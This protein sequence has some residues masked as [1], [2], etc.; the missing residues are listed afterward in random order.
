MRIGGAQ[1]AR[2]SCATEIAK[3]EPQKSGIIVPKEG[4]GI[5]GTLTHN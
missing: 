4:V 1:H 3:A 5:T 2:E